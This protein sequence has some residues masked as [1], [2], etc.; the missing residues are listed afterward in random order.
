[1][2]DAGI[3]PAN[4][5]ADLFQEADELTAMLVSSAKTTKERNA[6]ASS[7]R[8]NRTIREESTMY[9]AFIT[10][11]SL[12]PAAK[13]S[14]SIIVTVFG[15]AR[16]APDSKL[17]EESVTLGRLLGQAGYVV[18]TGGYTGTMEAVLRGAA[19]AGAHTIGYT[20][21]TFEASSEPN[22]WIKDERKTPTLTARIQRMADESDAFVVVHGGLGTL[23]E[24]ALVWNMIL[25]HETR[26]RPFIVVGAEWLQ[27]IESI[28]AHT[29]M[30]FSAS[31]LLTLVDSVEDV[32]VSLGG[33]MRLS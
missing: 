13:R 4:R 3:I 30:G 19:E 33:A 31:K 26:P 21:E 16:V 9:S 27:V 22:G 29:Q 17:Y 5:L 25:A 15:G 2:N 18:A 11:N 7:R 32:P 10:P 12:S 1:M 24:L 20:C 6:Q 14:G 28:R 8:S 23:A